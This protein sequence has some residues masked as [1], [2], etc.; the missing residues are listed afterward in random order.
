MRRLIEHRTAIEIRPSLIF[1]Q[2]PFFLGISLSFPS[3][4]FQRTIDPMGDNDQL[5]WLLCVAYG[6][7][8][9]V[10]ADLSCYSDES[11]DAADP[12]NTSQLDYRYE[13]SIE[14]PESLLFQSQQTSGLGAWWTVVI[15]CVLSHSVRQ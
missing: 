14:Q 8:W 10:L 6:L 15:G 4:S 5:E 2:T 11:F 9:F 13:V 12:T 1:K 7:L 3:L